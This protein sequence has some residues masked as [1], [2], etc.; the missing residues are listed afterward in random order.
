MPSKIK[1]ALLWHMHQPFY[2]DP[3]TGLYEMPWVR[4][5]GLKDYWG[6]AAM[7]EEFPRA[8][9]TFNLVSSLLMQ[10][11]DLLANPD[12]DALFRLAFLPVQELTNEEKDL[13]YD[14]FFQANYDHQ[15]KRFPRLL[16][17]YQRTH[18]AA[19]SDAAKHIHHFNEQDLLDLQV[20]SQLI[21]FDEI[22]LESDAVIHALVEKARGYTEEDKGLLRQK[23]LEVLSKI[24]PTYRRLSE[25]GQ[26]EISTSPFYHPILPLLCDS[27][28]ARQS[29]PLVPLP[30]RP[31]RWPADAALQIHRAV[32]YHRRLFGHRPAGVWPSEGSV[33]NASLEL[34]T[35]AAFRWTATDEGIL[36]RS[37]GTGFSRSASG[38]VNHSE[39]LH[40]PH[41][42][43]DSGLKIFFR[44]QEISDAIGFVFSRL[45]PAEAAENFVQRL[46]ASVSQKQETQPCVS[47]ILDGENAWEYFPQNGRPFL[48]EFY[49]RLTQD[50]DI[51][52]VTFAEACAS[53]ET[54]ARRLES[55]WPGSWINSNFAIWI[56]DSED[57]RAWELLN[58]ARET[59]EAFVR[60]DPSAANDP[61][62]QQARESLL[63]AEGSDWCWWYG[64]EH[65]TLNDLR[66]D[67]LFRS[68]LINCYRQLGYPISEILLQPL[69]RR[70]TK[71]LH[72]LPSGHIHPTIDGLVTN[73]F[74]WLGAGCIEES[75]T[76][77]H[78]GRKFF[79]R[80]LYGWDDENVYL[81][82]D[83]PESLLAT[84]ERVALNI[85]LDADVS[86]EFKNVTRPHLPILIRRFEARS[87][88]E[89]P[90]GE[91][92]SQG[93]YARVFE[94]RF[95]K[96]LLSR[97]A[98][99]APSFHVVIEVN[100]APVERLPVQGELEIDD[101]VFE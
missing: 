9:V 17:L 11:E 41:Q 25:R 18:D 98:E 90:L 10:I 7:L 43:K 16:E 93:V 12:L 86:L 37:L 26:I 100:G 81:R 36:A 29:S 56:G 30:S 79:E 8:H 49:R 74:E 44:D 6:M 20:L 31:F 67:R 58:E 22:Y 32:D 54:G 83:F 96:S 82:L 21:W 75:K 40:T 57:N 99:K 66:F 61:H 48:R 87:G 97:V 71:R 62:V 76:T 5:H 95:R 39:L 84:D 94:A 52:M 23:E 68:H 101:S 19:V 85:S 28:V 89:L 91:D 14:N 13:M 65:S 77:M 46:K 80:L 92:Q 4:L 2:K 38:E 33:S 47:V 73:Y 35:Q 60:A 27:S 70:V 50:P 59:L 88:R 51:E 78:H 3:V 69:K 72:V 63:I 53:H 55:I 34:L 15:I 24:I 42:F 64:P 45:D 1:L